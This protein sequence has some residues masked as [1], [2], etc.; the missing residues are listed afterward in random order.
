M[1]SEI[2][3]YS[4]VEYSSLCN[5]CAFYF[6]LSCIKYT[7]HKIYYIILKYIHGYEQTL[8]AYCLPY[9]WMSISALVLRGLD[10]RDCFWLIS[11][12]NIVLW[13]KENIQI[14]K[15][16]CLEN[17]FS[18]WQC[19]AKNIISEILL[20]ICWVFC[21]PSSLLK[22]YNKFCISILFYINIFIVNYARWGWIYL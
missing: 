10:G 14:L 11:L 17:F 20:K 3:L 8:L 6:A 1:Y 7:H 19:M 15:L 22:I 5:N 9:M 21:W 2:N 16:N 18:K 4:C 13:F 12:R